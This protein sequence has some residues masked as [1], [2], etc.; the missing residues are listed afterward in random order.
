MPVI[1]FGPICV[2]WAAIPPIIFFVGKPIWAILPESARQKLKSFWDWMG[3]LFAPIAE[4]IPFM[5]EVKKKDASNCKKTD[6]GKGCAIWQKNS[7]QVLAI[8]SEKTFDQILEQS[9]KDNFKIVANFTADWCVPCQKLKPLL[10]KSVKKSG[11][12]NL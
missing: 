1:C 2:P 5:K 6:E 3:E 7:K 12:K 11:Q 4:Y 9:K 8:D 10:N